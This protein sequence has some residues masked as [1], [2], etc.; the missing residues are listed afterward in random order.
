[1]SDV[2]NAYNQIM[3]FI[4]SKSE[5]TM[6]LC[7]VA[8]K[9]K[10]RLLLKALNDNGSLKGLIYLINTTRD[11]MENF[12]RWAEL[13]KVMPPKKYGQGIRISNLTLYFYNKT[14]KSNSFKYEDRSFDFI[15]FWPIQSVTKN[16]EEIQMLKEI[17]KHQNSNKIFFLTLHEPWTNPDP[18]ESFVDRVVRLDCENDAP[19][20]YKR[21]QAAYDEYLKRYM[22]L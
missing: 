5:K 7:G 15:I 8:D 11:G 6:L 10:H 1:M 20:E 13:N 21:I 9:E 3:E 18:F 22:Y 12:L 16:E 2:Q 19:E 4:S 17:A 14:I